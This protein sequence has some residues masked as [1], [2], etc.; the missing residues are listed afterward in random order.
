[1]E[2]EDIIAHN[3]MNLRKQ[4]GLTQEELG[5]ELG[6]TF[7]AVSRW[8]TGK[9]LPNAIMIKKIAD[10]FCV[11]VDYLYS[12]QD[13]II[14]KEQEDKLKR[15]EKIMK[16]STISVLVFFV[17]GILGMIVGCFT[18]NGLTGFLWSSLAVLIIALIITYIYKLKRF[19]LLAQSLSL[20]NFACCIFYQFSYLHN[21][22]M[23]FFFAMFGE[24]F[25]VLLHMLSKT[26]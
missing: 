21:M 12:E 17:L 2:L 3:L 26:H 24:I 15:K 9:S 11:S 22:T 7:Q 20:W 13:I 5:N 4:K 1:M 8:E 25:L 19:H 16:F 23:V 14:S 10:Y 6:Y 18:L